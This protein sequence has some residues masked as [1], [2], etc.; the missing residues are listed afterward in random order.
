MLSFSHQ[1][2]ISTVV[3]SG[4]YTGCANLYCFENTNHTA[5]IISTALVDGEFRRLAI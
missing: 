1:A 2:G 3:E 5:N 4:I